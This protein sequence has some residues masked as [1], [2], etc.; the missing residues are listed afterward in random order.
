METLGVASHPYLGLGSGYPSIGRDWLG[1]GQG[2][3]LSS[4][5][6]WWPVPVDVKTLVR[7]GVAVG[8]IRV[9]LQTEPCEYLQEAV[10]R[11]DVG[12][13]RAPEYEMLQLELEHLPG[14]T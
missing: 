5:H 3:S 7:S 11:G 1:S 14:R 13:W 4:G 6:G 12:P 9:V 2:V 10:Q 8:L